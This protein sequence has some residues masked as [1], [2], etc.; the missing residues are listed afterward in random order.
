MTLG[1][2]A[3]QID[4]QDA[5]NLNYSSENPVPQRRSFGQHLLYASATPLLFRQTKFHRG[6][7]PL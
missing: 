6:A 1:C 4:S 7:C 5:S 2:A 3:L